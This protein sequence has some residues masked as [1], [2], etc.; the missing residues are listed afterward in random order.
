MYATYIIILKTGSDDIT[1]LT[2]T[3][4]KTVD[5]DSNT[6]ITF[7]DIHNKIIG[8]FHKDHVIGFYK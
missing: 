5:F 8:V 7:M 1:T 2:L 6:Y 3:D 4:I